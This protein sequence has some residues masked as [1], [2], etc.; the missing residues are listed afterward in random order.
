MWYVIQVFTGKEDEAVSNIRRLVPRELCR[1]CFNPTYRMQKRIGG[2]WKTVEQPLFPGYV[3]VD[4]SNP[5]ALAAALRSVPGYTHILASEKG[6]SPLPRE[7][8]QWINEFTEE[9]KRVIG[10]S[11]GVIEGDKVIVTQGPLI[12]QTARISD[13]ERPHGK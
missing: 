12:N 8:Q 1:E 2:A 4:S 10:M 5:K 6:Y 9:G 7:E 11:T 3:I 13:D